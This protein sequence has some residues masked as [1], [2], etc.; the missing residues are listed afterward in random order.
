M[1]EELIRFGVSI[2]KNLLQQ[3]DQLIAAKGYQSRSEA[4]RDLVRNDLVGQEWEEGEQETFGTLTIV[5][6]HHI[7]N[8]T[9]T[10]AEIQHRF[11]DLI[12]SNVHVHID[13]D[14]CLEV[15]LLK[16]DNRRIKEISDEV[17]SLKGVKYGKLTAA[18]TGKEL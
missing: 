3:F 7:G 8:L 14:N 6:D 9:H 13:H 12:I 16:G 10:L 15:I 1:E 2:P 17:I 11:F 4:I 5:Y 18:T